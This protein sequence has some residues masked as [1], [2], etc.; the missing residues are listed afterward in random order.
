MR[1][2]GTK[3]F[4]I[5]AALMLGTASGNAQNGAA[6]DSYFKENAAQIAHLTRVSESLNLPFRKRLEAFS[7]LRLYFGLKAIDTAITLAKD[8]ELDLAIE[9][10]NFLNTMFYDDRL[11][12]NGPEIK[13]V[14]AAFRDSIND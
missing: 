10:M 1:R 9:S 8:P 14:N 7:T 13:K 2:P 5:S 4:L 11:D 6:P 3:A 12:A